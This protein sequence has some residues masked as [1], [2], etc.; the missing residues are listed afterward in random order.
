MSRKS[1]L[2]VFGS[3]LA[4][5]PLPVLAEEA[6]KGGLPQLDAGLYAGELFWLAVFFPLLY[7]LMRWVIVP[8]AQA[9]KDNRQGLLKGDL[10]AA[11]EA[12][13]QAKRMQA[14]YEK[15]LT[16]ARAKARET[17]AAITASASQEAA[18]QQTK[19]RQELESRLKET[20]DRM[21]ALREKAL[22]EVSGAARELADAIVEKLAG[23]KAKGGARS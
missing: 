7:V 9:T 12:S 1:I 21:T 2:S 16:D 3:S 13:E 17:V 19:Q 10:E 22:R 23:L 5:L 11:T 6:K 15:A 20:E 18:T 8:M 14:N 4:L